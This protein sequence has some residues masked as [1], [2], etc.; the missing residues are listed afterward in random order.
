MVAAYDELQRQHFEHVRDLRLDIHWMAPVLGTSPAETFNFLAE[1]DRLKSLR[2]ADRANIMPDRNDNPLYVPTSISSFIKA[3][4]AEL[5]NVQSKNPE[6][7][8]EQEIE[9]RV[10]TLAERIERLSYNKWAQK[11][12]AWTWRGVIGKATEFEENKKN[13]DIT[14]PTTLSDEELNAL[15]TIED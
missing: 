6:L 7:L 9:E 11:P 12:V 1:K 3:Y 14:S 4:D 5:R 15:F 8:S 13:Q 2:T 10:N